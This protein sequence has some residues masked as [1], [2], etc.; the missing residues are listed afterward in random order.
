M[1]SSSL[2]IVRFLVNFDGLQGGFHQI[3]RAAIRCASCQIF[4]GQLVG[5]G[6]NK[7]GFA[8]FIGSVLADQRVVGYFNVFHGVAPLIPF[9]VPVAAL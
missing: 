2:R 3:D 4:G 6:Q 8:L 7:G 1:V 9:P 5:H